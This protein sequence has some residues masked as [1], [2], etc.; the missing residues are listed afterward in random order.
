M[1]FFADDIVPPSPLGFFVH[2][3][4]L[5]SLVVSSSGSWE[6][7]LRFCMLTFSQFADVTSDM[8]GLEGFLWLRKPENGCEVQGCASN[9]GTRMKIIL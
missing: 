5:G 4:V 2:S 3:I 1:A 8:A 6:D 7:F 9:Q